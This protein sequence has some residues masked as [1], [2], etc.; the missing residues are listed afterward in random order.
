MAM[1]LMEP[2]MEV[3]SGEVSFVHTK[4]EWLTASPSTDDMKR[5]TRRP[6]LDE[7]PGKARAEV[8]S[9]EKKAAANSIGRFIT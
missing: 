5:D 6:V 1:F 4:V 9:P 8:S 3:V 7:R 2:V